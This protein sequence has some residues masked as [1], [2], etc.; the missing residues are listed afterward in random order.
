[1]GLSRDTF[2][3]YKQAVEDGGVE[4]LLQKDRRKPNPKNRVDEQTESSVLTYSLDFPYSG[5]SLS[6]RWN[7]G[8]LKF[9]K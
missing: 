5:L 9:F 6:Y 8:Q 1:M 2:Y 7:S 3:R 4:S